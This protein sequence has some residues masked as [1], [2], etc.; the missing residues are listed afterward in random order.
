MD[1]SVIIIGRNEGA[2]LALCLES[3]AK[4]NW[5]GLSHEVIYV[6]SRSTDNSL[7]LAA[8]SGA[9]AVLLEDD[10]PC[11]AKARNLG[12][13]KATGQFILFLDGD[14]ILDQQFVHKALKVLESAPRTCAVWGHRRE[15][16]P[17]QSI[18]TK[19]MDLDW[20]YP[21][22][23]TL[24]FGGDVLVRLSALKEVNG[25]DPTLT[26]GEEPEMCA[27]LRAAGWEI[28]HID[29][30]MTLHDLAVN[31]FRAYWLR[32]YRSGVAYAELA[33]R[34]RKRGDPLWQKDSKRFY[35]HGW[36]FLLSPL[37]LIGALLLPK[38]IGLPII[39]IGILGIVLIIIK[40]ARGCKWKSPNNPLLTIQYAI[41]VH[42]QKIPALFGQLAW[43]R[44]HKISQNLVEYN[45]STKSSNQQR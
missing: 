31:T 26:A 23:K 18:F 30:P 38:E 17:N 10:R 27:R 32:A 1:I 8:S 7:N 11:A 44:N 3:V 2:R 45:A 19:V 29:A 16:L 43:K 4:A 5:S 24:Y 28:E 42:L 39:S 14:T 33:E 9:M 22:G 36:L 25:Y 35:L 21:L 34:M 41:H 6:D 37:A 13:S 20:V 12:I 15:L 40:T